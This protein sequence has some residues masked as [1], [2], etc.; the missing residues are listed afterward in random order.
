MYD[1]VM[2]SKI[3]ISVCSCMGAADVDNFQMLFE[4]SEQTQSRTQQ[5]YVIKM[6]I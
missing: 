6:E 2:D 1:S 5:V 3:K 4:K